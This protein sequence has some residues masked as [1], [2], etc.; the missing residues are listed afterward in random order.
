MRPATYSTR[1]L[2]QFAPPHHTGEVQAKLLVAG[3]LP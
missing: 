2:D 3:G 1:S